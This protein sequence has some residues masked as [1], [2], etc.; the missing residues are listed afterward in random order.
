MEVLTLCHDSERAT[1][2]G[3]AVAEAVDARPEEPGVV[4]L[5][6]GDRADA[7]R[8]AMLTVGEATRIGTKPDAVFDEDGNP[9]FSDGVIVTE[10]ERGR[11]ELHV[12]VDALEALDARDDS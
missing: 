11:R 4:D 2:T 5:G 3:R 9:D 6:G 12:G 1:A 10:D 7:R 8:E